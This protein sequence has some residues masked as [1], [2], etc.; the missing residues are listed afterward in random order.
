MC[1]KHRSALYAGIYDKLK[2]FEYIKIMY[3]NIIYLVWI[4]DGG[5]AWY[6]SLYNNRSFEWKKNSITDFWWL[7]KSICRKYENCTVNVM[8]LLLCLKKT[9]WD[10]VF[11]NMNIYDE[12]LIQIFW[13]R[14]KVVLCMHMFTYT[15]PFNITIYIFK[16]R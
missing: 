6:I 10:R 5:I 16:L 12:E 3:Q 2:F 15:F 11:Y 4:W 9:F 13:I 8:I 1:V 14:L 7:L